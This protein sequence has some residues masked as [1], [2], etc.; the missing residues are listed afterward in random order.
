MTPA[1]FIFLVRIKSRL[2]YDTNSQIVIAIVNFL[3][4]FKLIPKKVK[5]LV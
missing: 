4:L 2:I 1:S 3:I 5:T